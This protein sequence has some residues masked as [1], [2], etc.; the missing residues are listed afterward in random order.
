MQKFLDCLAKEDKEEIACIFRLLAFTGM[1]K[2]EVLALRWK[3]LDFFTSRLSV[4]QI[5]AYGENNT[6][7]K[8]KANQSSV[9]KPLSTN[10]WF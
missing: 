4:S 6:Q 7:Q 1:R 5:V 8:S 2:S 9:F 3:D 10:N